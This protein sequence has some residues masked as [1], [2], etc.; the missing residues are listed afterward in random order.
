M[1]QR[2]EKLIKNDILPSLDFDDFGTCVDYVRGKLTNTNQKDA[3]RHSELLEVIFTYISGPL[4]STLYDNKYFVT[5]S[6]IFHTMGT[7]ISY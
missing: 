4:A 2:I 6:M 1:A 3:T 5:L 7:C